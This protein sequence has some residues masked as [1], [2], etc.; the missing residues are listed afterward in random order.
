M[1][2]LLLASLCTWELVEI[3]H[4]SSLMAGWRSRTDLWAGKLG[5]LLRCPFCL[6]PYVGVGLVVVLQYKHTPVGQPAYLL[7]C[8]LAVARLANLLNDGFHGL[9]RTPRYGADVLEHL[10]QMNEDFGF[11]E[12]EPGSDGS[13]GSKPRS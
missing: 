13:D 1:L 10:E 5:E 9:T 12:N 6:S 2:D 8:G 7:L 11:S 4:H 3:W